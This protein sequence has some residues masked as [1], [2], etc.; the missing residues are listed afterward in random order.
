M[1]QISDVI[2]EYD[3][4]PAP[5]KPQRIAGLTREDDR[6]AHELSELFNDMAVEGWE[7]VR[8]DTINIDDVTGIAGNVPKAH[9]LLVFRRPL[10]LP[11]VPTQRDALVLADRI[12]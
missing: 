7:Y 11:A 3:V 4:I 12:A 8:A 1:P 9:T 2:Y 5:K 6:V 10:I